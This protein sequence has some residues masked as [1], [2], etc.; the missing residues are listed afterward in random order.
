MCV[1]RFD[2]HCVWVNNCV[3]AFNARYFLLYL[4]TL[5]ATAATVAIIT[6]ALLVQVVL[7]S[8]MM[9]GSYIDDQGQERAVEL[10]FLI[11]VSSRCL[12]Y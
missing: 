9:H 6:A 2:H 12:C 8:D 3:G 1:Q 5:T 4:F 11:Q 10:L 7:L